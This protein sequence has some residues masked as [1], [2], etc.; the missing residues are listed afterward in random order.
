MQPAHITDWD[1]AYA[2]GAHIPGAD[3]FPPRWNDHAAAFRDTLAAHKRARLDIGY[4]SGEREV[5]DLF[6]PEGAARGLLVFVHGGYWRAF[7]KSTWSHFAAGGLAAGYAVALPSYSLC[8]TVKISDIT[9]QIARAINQ[10]AAS[11]SGPILL[12]G[13]SA[14]GHLVTRMVCA[15]SPL[16]QGVVGRVERVL[17]ISGL[18]DLRPLLK[19]EINRDLR[20]DFEEATRESPALTAPREGIEVICAVGRDERPEFIRQTELLASIWSGCGG[21]M[22]S[23]ILP[24]LHHFDVIDGLADPDS[25]LLSPLLS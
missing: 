10:V 14:G 18:H 13:H 15:S 5:L 25:A 6:M 1:D 24:G 22:T 19:T 11:V 2:N 21:V 3:A 7:D 4:G 20:L 17:S 8:P 12:A 16:S 23:R 9:V